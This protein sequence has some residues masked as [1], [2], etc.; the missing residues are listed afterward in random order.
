MQRILTAAAALLLAAPA[1]SPDSGD[2]ATVKT[3]KYDGLVQTV[4]DLQG[5]VVV[6]DFWMTT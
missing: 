1:V 3:V 4:H 5:K 6:V 2:T